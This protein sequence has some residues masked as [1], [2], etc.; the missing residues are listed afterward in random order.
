MPGDGQRRKCLQRMYD[1]PFPIL[2]LGCPPASDNM[3]CLWSPQRPALPHLLFLFPSQTPL[4]TS[5]PICN[6]SCSLSSRIFPRHTNMRSLPTQ[7]QP[8]RPPF[9]SSTVSFPLF[10]LNRKIS[11]KSNLSADHP[12]PAPISPHLSVALKEFWWRHR[13]SPG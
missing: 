6:S 3:G 8:S 13:C 2:Q 9:F 5:P 10:F 1:L 12:S 7:G 11:P 4:I